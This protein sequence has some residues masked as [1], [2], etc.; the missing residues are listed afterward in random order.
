MTYVASVI[1][2]N[3]QNYW[4]LNEG[5]GATAALDYGN[6][7]GMLW[8]AYQTVA[9]QAVFGPPGFG[10]GGIT[11]DGG[12]YNV[13]ANG[14]WNRATTGVSSVNNY[15]PLPDPGT[16]E[17]WFFNEQATDFCYLG[18]FVIGATGTNQLFG[19]Q[20]GDQ[21]AQI[22]SFVA[23]PLQV[24]I[25]PRGQ[26]HHVAMSWT[27]TQGFFYLDGTQLANFPY[28]GNIGGSHVA[29][30]AGGTN[31]APTGIN[32]GGLITEVATYRRALTVGDLDTHFD[33]A[34]LKGQ[35]PHW[36]GQRVAA[37][38]SSTTLDWAY[39]LG[40]THLAR[41]G[42]GSFSLPIGLR[43][44]KIDLIPPFPPGRTSAGTPLYL[45]D[46]GWCT[47]QNSDGMLE[48]IRPNRDTRVWLPQRMS[49]ATAFT[50]DLNPGWT[51]DV[52]ELDPA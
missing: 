51:I 41:Q 29:F 44:L 11:S 30:L 42:S 26:W 17:A 1:A 38:G 9:G 36:I 13:N 43:G 19:M 50:H 46:V 22:N 10:F 52:T 33:Q 47:I 3:P 28:P 32:Q 21:L 8:Y 16:L 15:T 35:R 20:L 34:E 18:W 7:P 49:V 6:L 12:S 24:A 23:T 25:A 31:L 4:R 5:A 14:L 2:S 39:S 40:V 45:W 48:E 37:A 27:G